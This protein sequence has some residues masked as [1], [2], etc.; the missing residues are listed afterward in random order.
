MKYVVL[1]EKADDGGWGATVPDL[2]GC[3]SWGSTRQE[4]EQNVR[5]AIVAHREALE[6]AGSPIPKPP[7]VD[8]AQVIEVA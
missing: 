1:Y 7:M 2:P 8:D 6:I 3:F 5:D 4:A